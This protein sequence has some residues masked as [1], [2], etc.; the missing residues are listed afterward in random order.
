MNAMNSQTKTRI[1]NF[2]KQ[3]FTFSLFLSLPAFIF[4]RLIFSAYPLVIAEDIVILL[5]SVLTGW[6]LIMIGKAAFEGLVF[7]VE[8]SQEAL[9]SKMKPGM[10]IEIELQPDNV[11]LARA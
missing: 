1:K 3:T 5:K 6:A 11:T 8:Y 2:L 10:S 4:I 9:Q 7:A